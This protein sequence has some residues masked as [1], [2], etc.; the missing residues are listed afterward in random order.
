[1]CLKSIALPNNISANIGILI[2]N[3]FEHSLPDRIRNLVELSLLQFCG[4]IIFVI[5][6]QYVTYIVIALT[7]KVI[8][9]SYNCCALTPHWSFLASLTNRW[10]GIVSE[11]TRAIFL[12]RHYGSRFQSKSPNIA[13]F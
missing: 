9:V 1:M 8:Y 7:H 4:N 3:V 10:K 11:H 12:L 6:E 2:S 13:Y 5:V